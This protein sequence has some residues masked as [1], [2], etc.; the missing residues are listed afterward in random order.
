MTAPSTPPR[1]FNDNGAILGAGNGP[2]E[3]LLASAKV[4]GLDIAPFADP[5]QAV[6]T[7]SRVGSRIHGGRL[8]GIVFVKP[9]PKF[10]GVGAVDQ[11]PGLQLGMKRVV[12]E[13]DDVLERALKAKSTKRRSYTSICLKLRLDF[14]DRIEALKEICFPP[15][16]ERGR[17]AAKPMPRPPA[18][19]FSAKSSPRGAVLVI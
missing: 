18:R 10:T 3:N 15:C 12:G 5:K 19:K 1:R 2:R 14:R 4:S 9:H 16:Q 7:A 17:L 6:R 11:K 8:G 13:G